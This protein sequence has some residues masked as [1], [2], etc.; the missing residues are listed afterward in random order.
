M[1]NVHSLR[2]SIFRVFSSQLQGKGCSSAYRCEWRILSAYRRVGFWM[3]YCWEV[4]CFGWLS[5]SSLPLPLSVAEQL[6]HHS[7]MQYTAVDSAPIKGHQESVIKTELFYFSLKEPSLLSFLEENRWMG[8]TRKIFKM[9]IPWN[10]IPV[11]TPNLAYSGISS[12]AIITTL[13]N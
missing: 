12:G 5:R 4:A 7:V 3:V 2:G 6:P 1:C 9:C 10:L 13:F 8:G 11:L